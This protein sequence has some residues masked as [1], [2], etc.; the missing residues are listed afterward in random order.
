[1]NYL[2]SCFSILHRQSEI[3]L[4]RKLSD[5][6]LSANQFIYIM[7]LCEHPGISQE[8]LSGF[9]RIDK[10]SVAK[11]VHQLS[12]CGYITRTVS[13]TDKRQYVLLPTKKATDLYPQLRDILMEY[14]RDLTGKLTPIEA[15][16]LRSLLQK[17]M[18][19]V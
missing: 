13:A 4:T 14:E 3:T 6:G 8:Q 16:I 7:C 5:F 9:L 15:D 19:N 10:G 2:L 11:S 12:D 1:M 18:K 17:L